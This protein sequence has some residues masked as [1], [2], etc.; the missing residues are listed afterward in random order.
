M[1]ESLAKLLEQFKQQ[2]QNESFILIS[3][4]GGADSYQY[5]NKGRVIGIVAVLDRIAEN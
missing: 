3:N 1:G 2:G 5:I 4:V